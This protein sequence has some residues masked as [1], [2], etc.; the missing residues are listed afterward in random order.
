ME[1]T[2]RGVQYDYQPAT[3]A[4]SPGKVG[5]KYRG[6]DVR[7]RHLRSPIVLKPNLDLV[8]RG[9]A[10]QANPVTAPQ[11]VTTPVVE[12]DQAVAPREQVA[13]AFAGLTVQD[14]ARS[15]MN[16]HQQAIKI[17]QQAMLLRLAEEVGVTADISEYWN[18][19]QGK[20]HP[21]FRATYDRSHAALS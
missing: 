20:I 14:Q 7:F 4:V 16:S 13:H 21:S 18:R 10:Y 15:L 12:A 11:S 9:V 3:V 17:R 2:Y 8:Y 6:L 19:I 5:G 1:L